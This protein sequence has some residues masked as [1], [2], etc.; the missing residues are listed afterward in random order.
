MSKSLP[1]GIRDSNGHWRPAKFGKESPLFRWPPS[2]RKIAR[3]LFGWGEF[4]F[5]RHASYAGL[6]VLTF[7]FL[8]PVSWTGDALVRSSLLT[9]LRN[10]VSLIAVYGFYHFTLYVKKVQGT[11]GKYHPKWQATHDKKF[12]FNNQ[13]LDNMFFCIVSGVTIWSAWE[14]LY[15]VLR[16]RGVAPT[17]QFETHTV[18]FIALFFI[19]PFW[20]DLH[21][22]TIH[23]LIHWPP[24]MR[25]VHTVHHRNYNPGPWSGMSMHPVEHILYLSV[26]AIFFIV[27]AHPIHIFYCLQITAL[28]PAQGH[29]GFHGPLYGGKWP[30]GDYFHYLHHK[31]V[32]CNFGGGVIP[33]DKWFKTYYNG[34]GRFVP[35]RRSSRR[36]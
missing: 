15:F 2:L 1:A 8:W 22:Y 21:F 35:K 17:I 30:V 34:E 36:K 13:V 16:A 4:S 19:I 28:A 12:L 23:R 14:I 10:L 29:T 20:R 18:W 7:F 6:A 25:T 5:P 33:L 24:L 26:V 32:G 31:Y 27:P 3:W 11:D 9:Y